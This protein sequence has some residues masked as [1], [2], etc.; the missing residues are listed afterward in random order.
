MNASLSSKLFLENREKMFDADIDDG[1]DEDDAVEEGV[2]GQP[3]LDTPG[4]G[5]WLPQEAQQ[6]G[7]GVHDGAVVRSEEDPGQ[8]G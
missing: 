3:P 2:V 8:R 7:D 4:V 5:Q 6:G 1:D